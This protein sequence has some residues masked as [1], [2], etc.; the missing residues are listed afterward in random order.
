M[1]EMHLRQPEF[2]YSA[3]GAFIKNKEII[4]KIKDTG[5]SIYIYQ[6]ELDK[7]C[8]QH[9]M[10]YGN[11]KDLPKRAASD[12]VLRHQAF[13][14]ARNPKYDRYQRGLSARVYKF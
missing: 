12:R 8:L 2:T 3:C 5:D 6:N 4:Q 10:A 11:F 7:A 14:I 9:G 1:A 13:N